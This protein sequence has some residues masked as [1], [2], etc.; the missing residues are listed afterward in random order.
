MGKRRGARSVLRV[1]QGME[2]S[3]Q[4]GG[5]WVGLLPLSTGISYLSSVRLAERGINVSTPEWGE[6]G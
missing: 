2:P 1:L 4:A 6:R 3:F 5:V